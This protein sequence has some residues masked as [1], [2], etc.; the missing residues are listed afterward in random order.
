MRLQ[1]GLPD[2]EFTSYR[3][4]PS[5]LTLP[6]WQMLIEKQRT[7]YILQT[8]KCC[9]CQMSSVWA[10]ENQLAAEVRQGDSSGGIERY[11]YILKHNL[12]LKVPPV[13]SDISAGI[14][15]P[16]S[17]STDFPWRLNTTSRV[18]QH[19]DP[20]PER[21]GMGSVPRH[22]LGDLIKRTFTVLTI[23]SC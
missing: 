15:F 22:E 6:F 18:Q 14:Y 16:Y 12:K 19:A 9:A 11:I 7:E 5:I 4:A 8:S 13:S 10:T 21:S 17:I 2:E 1:D 20:V 3:G 23:L